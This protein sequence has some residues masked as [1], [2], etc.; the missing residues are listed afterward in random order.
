MGILRK[1]LLYL[2]CAG[3]FLFGLHSQAHAEDIDE[4]LFKKFSYVA[5]NSYIPFLSHPSPYPYRWEAF[6]KISSVLPLFSSVSNHEEYFKKSYP[7]LYEYLYREIGTPRV[8]VINKWTN[9]V[10][11][12]IGYPNGLK[13]Y[14]WQEGDGLS[15]SEGACVL[16]GTYINE[17]SVE[18]QWVNNYNNPESQKNRY[19][20]NKFVQN[21]IVP[22]IEK[23]IPLL[24]QA[25][26]LDMKYVPAHQDNADDVAEIRIIIANSDSNRQPWLTP[27]KEGRMLMHDPDVKGRLGNVDE[28]KI[29]GRDYIYFREQV[30]SALSTAVYFTP[31]SYQQVDG[32]ILPNAD[33]SIGMAF[34]YLN[35]DLNEDIIKRLLQECL[36]RSLGLTNAYG[37]DKGVLSLWN[38]SF[39]Q[40]KHLRQYHDSQAVTGVSDFDLRMLGILYRKDIEP[41]MSVY[42]VQRLFN[43]E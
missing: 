32:Y 34:C 2:F 22:E 19:R 28:Y 24:R 33:N 37:F 43:K 30:E 3:L 16:K 38:D 17:P 26:G 5:F 6:N 13:P 29:D 7:W 11:I 41:G 27:F 23:N 12:S 40:P 21:I 8:N 20:D 31:Y 10:R 42:D 35:K 36:V 9:P 4:N 14:D 39:F 1:K 15:C 18:E 25:T